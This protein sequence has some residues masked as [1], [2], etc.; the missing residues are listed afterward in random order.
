MRRPSRMFLMMNRLYCIPK[1]AIMLIWIAGT[2]S[3]IAQNLG[4][5]HQN[6]FLDLSSSVQCSSLPL[7]SQFPADPRRAEQWK[8]G[9]M[10]NIGCIIA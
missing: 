4:V 8:E 5:L 2:T 9:E 1:H 6:D 7:L 10:W 3:M